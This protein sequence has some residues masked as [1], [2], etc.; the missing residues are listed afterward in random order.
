MSTNTDTTEP[1]PID[2]PEAF[3]RERFDEDDRDV[4]EALAAGD[5][6]ELSEDAERILAILDEDPDQERSER[7]DGS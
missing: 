1:D 3:I 6:E 7:R 5:Y 4:L 2:E